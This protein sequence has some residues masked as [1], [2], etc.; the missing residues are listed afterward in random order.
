M[1]I[2]LEI[3]S[4]KYVTLDDLYTLF[5]ADYFNSSTSVPRSTYKFIC[6]KFRNIE[7][8]INAANQQ[9]WDKFFL[10]QYSKYKISPRGLRNT[11]T[12]SF[13][14]T[15]LSQ[16]WDSISEFC[17]QKWIIIVSK[18]REYQ[19][20]H[21]R[22]KIV[23]L[24]YSLKTAITSLPISWLRK[25]KLNTKF[26]EDLLLGSKLQKIRRDFDDYNTNRVFSWKKHRS[27]NHE[28]TTSHELVYSDTGISDVRPLMDCTP[29]PTAD[30]LAKYPGY[31]R[32]VH[33]QS[34]LFTRPSLRKIHTPSVPA[35][36]QSSG[37]NNIQVELPPPSLIQVTSSSNVLVINT[38]PDGNVTT[39]AGLVTAD[40]I[41]T[42]MGIEN[43]LSSTSLS[44][45]IPSSSN[46]NLASGFVEPSVR[47]C[48]DGLPSAERINL[49]SSFL[50]NAPLSCPK[51][52]L[53]TE[54][55]EG[56][57]VDRERKGKL[58][59]L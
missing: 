8:N 2:I 16:E 29:K 17:T 4:A 27:P 1:E 12:C 6:A 14:N 19:Y 22:S 53:S 39:G 55:G 45:S 48:S 49:S 32:R 30:I 51:R 13:L 36:L 7:D 52:K 5:P 10:D 26:Q 28:I 31:V 21:F 15:S 20:A 43:P 56:V 40:P 57:D 25:L 59:K 54:A 44:A 50:V 3:E 42:K 18:Q 24:I 11:K 9:W 47:T 34:R 37:L 41:S 35:V 46:P 33:G 38:A 58:R 23:D